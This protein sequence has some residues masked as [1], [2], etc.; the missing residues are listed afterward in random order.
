LSFSFVF[1]GDFSSFLIKF[2]VA[3]CSI[4]FRTTFFFP[5]SAFLKVFEPDDDLLSLEDLKEV[6]FSIE[7]VF[8]PSLESDEI[9]IFLDT[10]V[11]MVK[12]FFF[13]LLVYH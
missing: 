11:E 9:S 12:V 1:E 6:F 4:K 8:F 2:L 13:I 10:P 3:C 7:N 5:G